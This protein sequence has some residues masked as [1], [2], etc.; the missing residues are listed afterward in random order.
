MN[1]SDSYSGTCSVCGWQGLFE[2][3]ERP[4]REGFQCRNCRGSLRYQN[5]AEA[6][7]ALYSRGRSATLA[8]LVREPEFQALRV[9]EPGL[10]G[11]LRPYLST[12]P[13]YQMSYY[14]PD[15]APGETKNGVRSENLEALTF[16]DGSFDLLISSDI[17][18]HVRRPWH[19][20]AETRR[21]L[22]NHGRHVFTV[23]FD[24]SRD[25]I[26]R[27]DVVGDEDVLLLP[28]AYHGSPTDSAGSL[29]YNDFGRDLP[30]RLGLLGF[31]VTVHER[32]RRSWTFVSER[33][34]GYSGRSAPVA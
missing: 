13:R 34:G 32:M 20:F 26:V 25:T 17:F 2:R 3:G 28:A 16:K 15:V 22:R 9:Y 18:E 33:N 31:G 29:V 8:Q 11:P 12:L 4:W 1:S 21:V 24:P 27:V 23:P 7:V 19:G 14:W 30:E 10:T 6:L 5:Q